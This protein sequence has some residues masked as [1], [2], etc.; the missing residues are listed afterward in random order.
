METSLHRDLKR[1]FAATPEQVE[2]TIDGYRIDAI[3][4][5]GH[6][7]EIQHAGLG[8]IRD[9]IR[10][11]IQSYPVR[12]VKPL[13]RTK[14]VETY[15]TEEAEEPQRRRKSPKHASFLEAFPEL[16]HFTSAYPH[17]N[18]TVEVL[19]VDVIE[20]RIPRPHRYR[21]K[22]QF[23]VLDQH[24]HE[25]GESKS[26]QTHLD[27]W[28]LLETPLP[29]KPFGTAEI[30]EWIERPRWF[31]QQVAYVLDRCGVIQQ[32]D[33]QGN[34]KLYAIQ[35]ATLKPLPQKTLT[36]KRKP[37]RKAG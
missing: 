8:S 15:E 22:K 24:L 4:V 11:L 36:R 34:A 14:W 6:L 33:K 28:N 27:L 30:A 3:D 20:R 10:T 21:R 7:V 32:V 35:E 19:L 2:V 16:L 17:P 29:K 26:L 12:V 1:I 13:L 23:R 5:R 31:A 9:K 25:C 37:R 18:L